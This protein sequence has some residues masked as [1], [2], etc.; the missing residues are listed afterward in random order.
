[1]IQEL[2][3]E[4]VFMNISFIAEP[5]VGALIGYCTN[6]IAV[7]ML[8]RPLKPVKIGN[9][10]LP[11]TP[12]IIPKGKKR[13]GQAI[14]VAVGGT[15]LTD[16]ALKEAL[17]SE[18]MLQKVEEDVSA[19]VEKQRQNETTLKAVAL[20]YVDQ[21]QYDTTIEN[22]ENSITDKIVENLSEMN[23]GEI[24]AREG[25][26]AIKQKVSGSFLGMMVND[27]LIESLASPIIDSINTYIDENGQVIVY[28]RVSKQ[29]EKLADSKVM[30]AIP[31]TNTV[32]AK[33]IVM[34]VYINFVEKELGQ[35]IA[36]INIAAIIER[37]IDEMDVMELE[38]LILS[39]MKKELSA[40]VNLGALIGL[41]LGIVNIFF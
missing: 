21:I 20:Q 10:T 29:C 34:R 15:L 41:V 13:L 38:E 8:F 31:A 25:I 12:G 3:K 23:I 22:I 32:D 35:V 4:G 6:Y 2:S 14:G 26:K 18:E 17:L 33:S 30:D 9:Y 36:K 27:S 19:F 24:I 16:E 40:V 28:D 1:M 7:K 37:K 11:F 39:V 5:L